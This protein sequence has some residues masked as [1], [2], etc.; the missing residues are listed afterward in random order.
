VRL[1]H[2]TAQEVPFISEYH[3]K[4]DAVLLREIIIEG[5]ERMKRDPTYKRWREK[6]QTLQTIQPTSSIEEESSSS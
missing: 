5:T 3:H 1:D 6:H 4:K 2:R